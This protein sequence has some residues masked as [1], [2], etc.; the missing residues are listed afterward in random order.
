M[1]FYPESWMVVSR[2]LLGVVCLGCIIPLKVCNTVKKFTADPQQEKVAGKEGRSLSLI[3]FLPSYLK[4]WTTQGQTLPN[5][6]GT[7]N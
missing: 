6:G 2:L 5:Q 1:G 7:S 4:L 3:D